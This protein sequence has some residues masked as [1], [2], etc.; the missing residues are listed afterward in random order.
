[1]RPRLSENVNGEA[2]KIEHEAD[3][4]S[5]M[6]GRSSSESRTSVPAA[7]TT[8]KVHWHFPKWFSMYTRDKD[9]CWVWNNIDCFIV[10]AEPHATGDNCT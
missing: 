1:M 3:N 10:N 9:F 2:N 5:P 7:G 6:S 8:S 4:Q